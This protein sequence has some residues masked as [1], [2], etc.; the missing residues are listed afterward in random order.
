MLGPFLMFYIHVGP[1]LTGTLDNS[2][3]ES[4]DTPIERTS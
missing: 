1:R 4:T 2:K 3:T